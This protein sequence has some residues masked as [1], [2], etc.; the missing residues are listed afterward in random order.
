MFVGRNS[1]YLRDP[2]LAQAALQR[3]AVSDDAAFDAQCIAHV[4]DHGLAEHLYP[5]HLLKSWTAVRDEIGLGVPGA[6]AQAL[7]A[8]VNRLFG[9][10]F[11]QR[12]A[13]RTARQALGFDGKED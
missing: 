2:A 9:A 11:K 12:H 6:T 10:R 7:R 13:M 5:A 3:W 8:A 4:L 1:A